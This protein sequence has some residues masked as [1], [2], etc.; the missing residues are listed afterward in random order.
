MNTIIDNIRI[1]AISSYL[2][3]KKLELASLGDLYGEKEVASIIKATGIE[4]V[5]IASQYQTASDLCY[6]AAK[7]LIE[8]EKI[9][10]GEIGGLVF[11]SQTAD[12]IMPSTSIVLQD[13]LGLSNETVCVDISSGCTG[14]IYGLF[15]AALWINCGACENVLLL[16]GDTTSKLVNPNDKSVRMIFGDC[17]T[18]TLITKGVNPMGFSI[19]SDGSGYDRVI[20]PAGGFRLP[21]SEFTKELTYDEN[22]NGR[23]QEDIYM[24]GMAA[25]SLAMT[26]VHK[27]VNNL[28]GRMSWKKEEV[29]LYALHQANKFI[30]DS[31]R[32]KLKVESEKVPINITNYGNTGPASI[33]LLLSDVFSCSSDTNLKQV[34]LS[35]IGVGLS[36]GSVT[37]NLQNCNFNSPIN[38]YK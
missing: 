10:K 27:N 9:D 14:Y 23:T 13:R 8:S 34:I 3:E 24:D 5:R 33:P 29:N 25:F 7:Q 18:A 26:E 1:S 2:P 22:N 15:Q 35:A 31:I 30:I 12:Y 16:A 37:C 19:Y 38:K 4:R 21:T 28:I 11:V 6:E 36:W 17:G 32:K 20:V